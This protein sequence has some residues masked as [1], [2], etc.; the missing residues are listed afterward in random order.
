MH[1]RTC[2]LHVRR[3]L[4]LMDIFPIS[5]CS[6]GRQSTLVVGYLCMGAAVSIATFANDERKYLYFFVLS[7]IGFTEAGKCLVYTCQR[8]Q[9]HYRRNNMHALM[10]TQAHIGT[11]K[12]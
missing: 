9:I 6:F 10:N 4:G 8:M 11:H 7:F 1:S 2:A 12:I 5:F 3:D